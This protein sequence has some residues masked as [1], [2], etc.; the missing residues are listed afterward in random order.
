M[1]AAGGEIDGSFPHRFETSAVQLV[2]MLGDDLRTLSSLTPV[3]LNSKPVWVT[4]A[5]KRAPS[6]NSMPSAPS[7]CLQIRF[8]TLPRNISV[9][10]FASSW[11]DDDINTYS[12]IP[13]N[14]RMPA[15]SGQ[16]IQ[17]HVPTLF[18]SSVAVQND[19]GS[20]RHL[21]LNLVAADV[22][23]RQNNSGKRLPNRE[24]CAD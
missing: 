10:R 13:D 1:R 17:F 16:P 11:S 23:P 15:K 21:T 22:S 2:L 3:T 12:G 19:F 4:S 5:N 20:T 7:R 8:T 24:V 9:A 6:S 18:P 14:G